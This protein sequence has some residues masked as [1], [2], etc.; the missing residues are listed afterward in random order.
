MSEFK[1]M[2]LKEVL[3]YGIKSEIEAW[4]VYD[5]IASL[6]MPYV[7]KK[8]I[9]FVKEEEKAHEKTLR[10]IFEDIFPSQEPQIPEELVSGLK[11]EADFTADIETDEDK[12]LTELLK[13]AMKAEKNAQEYHQSLV[14]R[15]DDNSKAQIAKYLSNMEK[16]HYSI[17][18]NEFE[19][20]RE[21]ENF[22]EFNKLMHAGP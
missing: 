19:A 9:E 11:T 14:E 15:F 3:E 16:T 18:E 2:D 6:D 10:N 13:Q 22:D 8:K 4:K 17:I 21:F 12:P 7:M 20:V 1:N 5:H